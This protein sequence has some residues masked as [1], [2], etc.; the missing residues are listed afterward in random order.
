[1][2]QALNPEPASDTLPDLPGLDTHL[3]LIRCGGKVPF[4]RKL[5]LGFL[6][7]YSDIIERIRE[8]PDKSVAEREAHTLKGVAGN[9]GAVEVAEL[10]AC[11]ES[12]FRN[13]EGDPS[14]HLNAAETALSKVLE[15]LKNLPQ[16]KPVEAREQVQIS[17]QRRVE[18]CDKLR[19]LLQ[20]FDG[21]AAD[22]LEELRP[23]VG[24]KHD[25]V[26]KMLEDAVDG[27]EFDEALEHLDTLQSQWA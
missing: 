16:E 9:L 22:A 20:D 21:E 2:T 27:F 13:G 11:L 12:H 14:E 6:R 23:A 18:L 26:L 1:M 3:G 24:A 19:G 5:L 25:R 8:A 15:G 7:D 17:P 4:Y 10:A